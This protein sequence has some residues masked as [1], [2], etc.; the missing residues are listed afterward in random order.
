M[1]LRQ[2]GLGLDQQM[3]AGESLGTCCLRL[4]DCFFI[5]RKHQA[6]IY[7]AWAFFVPVPSFLLRV[8]PAPAEPLV[9]LLQGVTPQPRRL[10]RARLTLT[11]FEA[12]RRSWGGDGKPSAGGHKAKQCQRCNQG[13]GLIADNPVP[14]G[15]IQ[16]GY[17]DHRGSRQRGTDPTRME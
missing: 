5:F 7:L 17:F 6:F 14:K 3:A 2:A 12:G 15:N 16:I 8:Q 10:T 1:G 11:P 13:S 4:T 9:P